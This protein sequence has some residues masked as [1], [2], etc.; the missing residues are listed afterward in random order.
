MQ[1]RDKAVYLQR[2]FRTSL[3]AKSP[4]VRAHP[5]GCAFFR[6]ARPFISRRSVSE[7]VMSCCFMVFLEQATAP[8][9][10]FL[11]LRSGVFFSL[12]DTANFLKQFEHGKRFFYT[13]DHYFIR[14]ITQQQE[15]GDKPNQ[16]LSFSCVTQSCLH[17]YPTPV[18]VQHRK[19]T[20]F[21]LTQKTDIAQNG[22]KRPLHSS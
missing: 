5:S 20:T 22:C 9:R 12:S 21:V 19:I 10:R 15:T 18:E 1:R 11:S 3:R 8:P 13:E 14:E 7:G 16:E 6:A 2:F 4:F 17:K